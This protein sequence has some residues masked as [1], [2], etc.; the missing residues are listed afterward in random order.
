M[1]QHTGGSIIRADS[2]DNGGGGFSPAAA[3]S[4]VL[5]QGAVYKTDSCAFELSG[6]QLQAIAVPPASPHRPGL[7]HAHTLLCSNSLK[8]ARLCHIYAWLASDRWHVGRSMGRTTG[9]PIPATHGLQ[10]HDPK[11]MF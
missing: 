8:P 1:A 5:L 7:T 11:F 9:E 6:L 4:A 2:A 3:R 10:A